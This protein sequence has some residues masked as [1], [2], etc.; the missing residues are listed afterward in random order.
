MQTL[1]VRE[2]IENLKA[3]A[4]PEA[5]ERLTE[6]NPAFAALKL[7]VDFDSFGNEENELAYVGNSL[8]NVCEGIH[9]LHNRSDTA[10]AALETGLKA[11]LLQLRKDVGQK[12]ARFQEGELSIITP[13]FCND[14][15]SA[16]DVV[17]ALEEGL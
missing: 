10:K 16:N 9:D 14:Y 17:L 3:T 8:S 1:R 7:K 4:I 15:L 11:I 5:M 2:R 6:T 12:S 13:S